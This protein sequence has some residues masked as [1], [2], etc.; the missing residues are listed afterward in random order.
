KIIIT[1]TVTSSD[2]EELRKAGVQMLVTTTPEMNGRSFGTNVLQAIFVA[3]L[4]KK[5][6]DIA[7]GDY[8]EMMKK[9]GIR[10]RVVR[11]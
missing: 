10:P 9:M 8:V 6:E 3:I 11:F 1:N 2:I 7:P 5:P 4:G